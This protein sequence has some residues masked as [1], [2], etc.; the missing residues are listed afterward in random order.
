MSF[1]LCTAILLGTASPARTRRATF[2]VQWGIL[3]NFS[4]GIAIVDLTTQLEL[5]KVNPKVFGDLAQLSSSNYPR[6]L[7]FIIYSIIREINS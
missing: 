5:N 2:A 6:N 3:R 7:I 1:H 4:S